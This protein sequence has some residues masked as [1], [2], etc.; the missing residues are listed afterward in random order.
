M[1]IVRCRLAGRWATAPPRPVQTG[2]GP[3]PPP[4]RGGGGLPARP[5]AEAAEPA[6]GRGGGGLPPPRPAVHRRF[7]RVPGGRV[8]E[9]L[10]N[11]ATVRNRVKNRKQGRN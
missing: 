2:C 4:G 10:R 5:G 8:V 1:M 9:S 6:P 3:R 11:A 7:G